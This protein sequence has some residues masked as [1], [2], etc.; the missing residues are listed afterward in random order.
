MFCSDFKL[1][2]LT[3][4]FFEPSVDD[5]TE[6]LFVVVFKVCVVCFTASVF[7]CSKLLKCTSATVTKPLFGEKCYSLLILT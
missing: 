4:C 6:S 7:R 5:G 2:T 1:D 3:D